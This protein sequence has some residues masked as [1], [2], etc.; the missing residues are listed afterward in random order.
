MLL[1][2]LAVVNP[3]FAAIIDDLFKSPALPAWQTATA[4]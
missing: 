3:R 1:S 2:A 4:R